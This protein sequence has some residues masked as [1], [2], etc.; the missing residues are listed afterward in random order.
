MKYVIDF[1]DHVSEQVIEQFLTDNNITLLKQLESFGKVYLVQT[2][3]EIASNELIEDISL[4]TEQGI[5]LLS[6]SIDLVDNYIETSFDVEDEKN[7]WKV[8]TI[9]KIDFDKQI[10]NHKIRGVNSTVYIVDSGITVSHPEFATA[11]IELL[12]SF[13]GNFTD[14]NGHGTAL[15]SLI[16][17]SSC[18]L[19]NPKLKVV[20]VFDNNQPTYQSDMLI[21]LDT[22]LADFINSSKKSSVV[23]MSWAIPKNEYVNNKIQ[24]MINQGMYVVA[25]AGNNGTPITDVTPASIPDVLTIG[26]FGQ[27]LTPSAFS[28]YTGGS[29]I[30]YTANDVNY[31]A[32]DGWAPGE[33]IWAA[34]KN[35][36]YGYIAGT[37]ASSA[38]ASA[39]IA[40]NV[41]ASLTN[42]GML[43][44]RAVI[45]NSLSLYNSIGVGRE[46]LLDL[47]DPLY[48]NSVNKC[49]TFFT[50]AIPPEFYLYNREVRAG[51]P[52]SFKIAKPILVSSI[53]S[54]ADLPEYVTFDQYGYITINYNSIDE[55]FIKLPDLELTYLLKTGSTSTVI[56][57]I[58]VVNSEYANMKELYETNSEIVEGDDFALS[59]I[60]AADAF[61][62]DVGPYSCADTNFCYLQ[63]PIR[64]CSTFVKNNGCFCASA[65]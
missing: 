61:C 50:L 29:D 8:A 59:Y 47:S 63:G 57:R 32:L 4:D 39:A 21:A 11:N 13:N 16:V 52:S 49:V 18:G 37:S 27:D 12:H 28:N 46:D 43:D 54:D 34:N 48:D 5:E 17:G 14:N 3:T 23:N 45:T 30:S 33:Q 35:G 2:E 6:F 53:I 15:S 40:Y 51:Y 20:K 55:L 26:S 19:A 58:I 41:D 7:W 25:A 1:Y 36:G 56:V 44:D 9:N 22:I 10:N 24:H 64:Y 38:I 42:G 60:L 62:S 65:Y 31:G